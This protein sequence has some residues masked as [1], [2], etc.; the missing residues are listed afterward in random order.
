MAN[1]VPWVGALITD[2]N[3]AIL[4]VCE[5]GK[6][7]ETVR[8]LARVGYDNT[9]GYLDGGILSWRSASKPL[10]SIT[11]INAGEFESIFDKDLSII[12]VR[13]PGEYE[14]GHIVNAE[15]KPLDFIN[16]WTNSI[17]RNETQYIHCAGGYRS[18]IAASIL[19]SRGYN[20]LVEV[21]G[22]YTAISKT[23]I[24]QELESEVTK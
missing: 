7:E 5:D 14:G 23:S 2:L 16:E 12:D 10:D 21:A 18:M 19:K 11:S 8:R 9:L 1:F 4:I 20:N 22:G 15:S 17:E 24:P 3:Q 13:K 6:E